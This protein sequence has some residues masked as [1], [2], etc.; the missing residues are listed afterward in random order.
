MDGLYTTDYFDMPESA[1]FDELITAEGFNDY[2]ERHG[3][4]K[5]IFNNGVYYTQDWST[6]GFITHRIGRMMTRKSESNAGFCKCLIKTAYKKE[7]QQ[8]IKNVQSH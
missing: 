2:V 5:V 6:T 8:G 4:W 7:E 1:H 3:L